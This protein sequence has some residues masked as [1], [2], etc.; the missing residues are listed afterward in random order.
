[1]AHI[2]FVM[3]TIILISTIIS[4]P[5]YLSYYNILAG[6]T[7]NGYKIAT[8]SNYDW[9]QDIKRLGKW[10]RNNNVEKIYVHLFSANKLDYYLD[11]KQIWFNIERDGL[12]S[13]G[14]YLA[15]S[16]QELQNNIYKQNLP[17]NKKYSQLENNLMA[18]I[19]K[20]IFIFKIP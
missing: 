6:G 20:S 18:R 15:V 5:H 17:E 2:A 8:D 9:G 12:P 3:L 19:G 13:S 16:A 10:V 7:D 1:M 14:S 4:F 11:D